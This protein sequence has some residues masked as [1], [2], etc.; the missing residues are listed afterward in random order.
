MFSHSECRDEQVVLLH[1]SSDC[2]HTRF[3]V[4]AIDS[5]VAFDVQAADVTVCQDIEQRGLARATREFGD[6]SSKTS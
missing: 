6:L 3:D 4:F 1:V 5:D 2:S